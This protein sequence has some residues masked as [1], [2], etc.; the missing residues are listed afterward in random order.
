MMK[1]F[2]C[3]LCSI[4]VLPCA[5]QA[6]GFDFS[7]S[8]LAGVYYGV[9]Q[10]RR[11]N[12]YDNLPNRLVYRQDGRFEGAYTFADKTR[13]GAHADYT[14]AL[15]QHDKDYNGGDW[16][17]YPYA[18]AENP[19]YGK[20]TVGYSYNAARQLHMGAQDISWIG[21]QDGNLP[22]FLTDVN[23]S[24]GLKK[25]KFATPK[26]T[27]IMDDGR[28]VK[29]VYFT[30]MFGNTK[31]G[32]SYTPENASRRGMVS[33]YTDYETNE[34]GYT[35]AMQ[36]KWSVG[37]GDVYTSAAYGEFNGTDKEW[38]FGIRWI[39][40]NFNISTSYKKAYIDG[41]KNP[42]TTISDNPYLPA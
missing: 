14:L 34:D 4:A 13:L 29:F 15:R 16:R 40:D 27:A 12:N 17:F 35:A 39:I 7:Q 30:P 26:S 24:N 37:L 2:S 1:K 22:N 41:N 36:N 18:L 19:A 6:D 33:R 5:A 3:I 32:F 21:I 38:A 20:F 23:W 31:F 42:I 11:Q 8:G 28:A 9:M 25:T 10:T